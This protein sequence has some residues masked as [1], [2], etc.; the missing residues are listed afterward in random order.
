[1][2]EGSVAKLVAKLNLQKGVSIDYRVF[3]DADHFFTDHAEAIS[4]ATIDHVRKALGLDRKKV[5][6]AAD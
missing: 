3:E 1:V 5:A 2:P 6:L 4:E